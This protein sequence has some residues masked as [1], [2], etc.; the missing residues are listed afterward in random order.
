MSSAR[1]SGA[2]DRF[3]LRPR[4]LE[5]YAAHCHG[6]V[7]RT[8]SASSVANYPSLVMDCEQWDVTETIH[9]W[10]QNPVACRHLVVVSLDL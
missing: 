10:S 6:V 3:N 8:L 5:K 1:F 9:I 4:K 7:L 2:T